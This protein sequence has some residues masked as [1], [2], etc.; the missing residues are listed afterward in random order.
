MKNLLV[1]I[2]ACAI[3]FGFTAGIVFLVTWAFG[4]QFTWKIAFGVWVLILAINMLTYKK[5]S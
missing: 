5:T 1:I 2:M 3:S 4:W